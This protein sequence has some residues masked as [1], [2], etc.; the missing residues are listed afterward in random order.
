MGNEII[1]NPFNKIYVKDNVARKEFLS[2]DK[3]L[4]QTWGLLYEQLYNYDNRLVKI[5]DLSENHITME[6]IDY[7]YT[8]AHYVR[9]YDASY[10]EERLNRYISQYMDIWNNFFQFSF[11]E[12]KTNIFYHRDYMLVNLVV[13]KNDNLRLIDPD[14]FKIEKLFGFV[15]S[16]IYFENLMRLF[17]K[18]RSYSEIVYLTDEENERY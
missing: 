17:E 4:T 11:N 5:Y 14:S 15:K 16:G 13:D 8:L 7:K 9:K 2:P 10:N 18:R 3:K 12:L 6:K 1:E